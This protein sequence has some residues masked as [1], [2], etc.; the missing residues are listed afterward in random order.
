MKFS[1]RRGRSYWRRREFRAQRFELDPGAVDDV[2][3][4][5]ELFVEKC[6]GPRRARANRLDAELEH[7]CPEFGVVADRINESIAQH[8]ADVVGKPSFQLLT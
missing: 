8:I 3:P 1:T 6:L 4:A 2:F 5:D 7:F